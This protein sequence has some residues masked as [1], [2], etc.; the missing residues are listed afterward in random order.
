MIT[1]YIVHTFMSTVYTLFL[2]FI[3]FRTETA[4]PSSK[5]F[6]DKKKFPAKQK[7]SASSRDI[8]FSAIKLAI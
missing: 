5:H 8:F 4:F 3:F 6:Q 2:I 7:R 1:V